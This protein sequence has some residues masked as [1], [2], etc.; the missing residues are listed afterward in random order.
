M[1]YKY[2]DSDI[3]EFILTFQ[4]HQ[5]L[6]VKT[7]FERRDI[8]LLSLSVFILIMTFLFFFSA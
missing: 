4:T 6:Q 7:S 3:H 2:P 5:V 8:P 1:S